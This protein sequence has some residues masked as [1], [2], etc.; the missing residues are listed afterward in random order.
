LVEG[1]FLYIG[2]ADARVR[3]LS[4]K[5][6]NDA[7]EAIKMGGIGNFILIQMNVIGRR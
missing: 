7:C 1:N 6:M 4:L 3:V 5:D 2:Q